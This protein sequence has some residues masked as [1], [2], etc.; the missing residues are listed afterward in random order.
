MEETGKK[1]ET[2]S[3]KLAFTPFQNATTRSFT[4][5]LDFFFVLA[6]FFDLVSAFFPVSSLINYSL[7]ETKKYCRFCKKHTLHKETK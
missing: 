2:K 1:A 3:K 5:G 4:D 6:S 7:L